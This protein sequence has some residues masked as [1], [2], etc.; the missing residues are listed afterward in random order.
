MAE[1]ADPPPVD[2]AAELEA[3]TAQAIEA[4][5]GRS[6]RGRARADR[7]E[8]AARAGDGGGLRQGVEQRIHARAAS[9]EKA[10]GRQKKPDRAA[11]GVKIRIAVEKSVSGV[12][13]V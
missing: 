3:A 6:G 7:R 8:R 10:V 12:G 2:E 9:A 1:P 5:G 11:S 13:Q 4:C